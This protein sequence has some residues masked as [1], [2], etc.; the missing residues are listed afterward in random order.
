MNAQ[1]RPMARPRHA[2]ARS[3]R[4]RW[5]AALVAETAFL[6]ALFVTVIAAMSMAPLP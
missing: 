6:L 2:A 1:R 5:Y 3:A 4:I